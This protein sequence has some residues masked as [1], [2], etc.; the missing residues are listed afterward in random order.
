MKNQS[1]KNQVYEGILKDILDGVYQANA[2]INEKALIDKYNVSKT[3]VREAL[4]QLCSEG[5]LKNIPRFGYQL[6]MITPSEIIEMIEFRKIIEVGALEMSFDRLTASHL[7]E[8]KELNRQAE[9]ISKSQDIKVH[10]EANQMFHRKL[11]SFCGNRYLQKSLDD[12]LNFCTRIANQYFVKVWE[13]NEAEDG[14]HFKIVN[15]IENKN[16]EYAKEILIYDI[17]LM[18]NKIL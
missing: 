18:K 15:S 12:S 9:N 7:E 3:P 16:L 2:I 17:E 5:I 14:D 1:I 11:C 6:S 13:S 4:V 8:L 10:W